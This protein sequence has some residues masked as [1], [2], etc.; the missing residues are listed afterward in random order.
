MKKKLLGM[1]LASVLTVSMVS[2]VFA[3]Q[4]SDL[5]AARSQ[6]YSSLSTTNNN[7]AALNKKQKEIQSQVSKLNSDIVDLMVQ[8]D[9]AQKDIETTQKQIANTES[10]IS[11]TQQKLEAAQKDANSQYAAMKKRIQYTYE[12]GGR[13]GWLTAVLSSKS[14]TSFINSADYATELSETDRDAFEKLVATVN[15]V[16]E[17]KNSLESQKKSYEDQQASLQNMKKQLDAQNA[18]L[19]KQKAQKEAAGA[20][21]SAQI[22]AAQQQAKE[23]SDLISQQTAAINQIEE[24]KIAAAKA[25][26]AQAAAEAAERSEAR[27]SGRTAALTGASSSAGSSRSTGSSSSSRTARVSTREAESIASEQ[28]EAARKA[29]IRRGGSSSQAAEAASAVKSAV[30]SAASSGA[31]KSSIVDYANKYVGGKYSWGGDSLTGGID[32]SHFVTQVL[33]NT[34]NYSGGYRTSGE[35]A[36][37]GTSVSSLSDA[38]AGDVIV[39]SGHV[40]IYDGKGGQIEAQSSKA[41]ITNNRKVNSSKIVAIRRVSE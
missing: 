33:T 8:I 12:N 30:K 22:A 37:A 13:T 10:K 38:K 7:L 27:G 36:S 29:V 23:I 4:E 19:Q 41:G 3:D 16:T 6:A 14:F 5:K 21:Y 31:S 40:S 18:D 11:E 28:A 34:G 39:Y 24:Q 25:A 15:K 2:P 26:A 1:L 35:W 17:L 20:Q 32:C 9:Q